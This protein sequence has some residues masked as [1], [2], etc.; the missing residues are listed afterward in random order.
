MAIKRIIGIIFLALAV[1]IGSYSQQKNMNT[2]TRYVKVPAGYLMVLRQ[3]DNIF[4]Q[5]EKF[6]LTIGADV[7]RIHPDE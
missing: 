3:G 6:A 1:Q 2:N 7:L 5:L 4:E